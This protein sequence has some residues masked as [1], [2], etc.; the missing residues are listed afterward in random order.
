MTQTFNDALRLMT[1]RTRSGQSIIIIAIGFIVLIAF[2]GIA[3]DAALLFVRYST[4]RRAIDAAAVAA[5]GQIREN[6]S[7]AQMAAAAQQYIQVHGLEASSVIVD[8]CETEINN[9]RNDITKNI[10]GIYNGVGAAQAWLADIDPS[11]KVPR[12]DLCRKDPAKLVRVSAQIDS[13]TTFLSVLGYKTIR[14]TASAI[15]QTAVMD[16]VL[17][18]DGS[19][20]MAADTYALQTATRSNNSLAEYAAREDELDK[21]PGFYRGNPDPKL[22]FDLGLGKYNSANDANVYDGYGRLVRTRPSDG[23]ITTDAP[24]VGSIR[25]ECRVGDPGEASRENVNL[26]RGQLGQFLTLGNY[27]W[28]GCCNDPTTQIDASDPTYGNPNR[29][30]DYNWFIDARTGV[31]QTVAG[32]NDPNGKPSTSRVKDGK[33]DGNF[34]DLVCR[35]FKDV[36]DATRRFL[37]K[38]DFT[39]GD[40]AIMIQFDATAH[41]I[42]P[43]GG[44]SP[45]FIDRGS[46]INALNKKVGIEENPNGFAFSCATHFN[47]AR[48]WGRKLTTADPSGAGT[49]DTA[50]GHPLGN[51]YEFYNTP[52]NNSEFFYETIAPCPDTNTGAAIQAGTALLADPTWIRRDAVWIAV[53]LSDGYP[54]RTPGLGV[55]D[56]DGTLGAAT[57]GLPGVSFADLPSAGLTWNPN[58]HQVPAKGNFTLPDAFGVQVAY[59][60]ATNKS[61]GSFFDKPRPFSS[62]INDPGFCPWS[63]FC[64]PIAGGG[65]ANDYGGSYSE[66]GGPYGSYVNRPANGTN[67]FPDAT[68]Q[69]YNSKEWWTQYCRDVVK[70]AEPM[71]WSFVQNSGAVNPTDTTWHEGGQSLGARKPICSSSNP[72]ARHFCVETSSG[73]ISPGSGVC[74]T[75]YDAVDFA[76]DRVDFAAL[77][78]YTPKF[79]GNFIAMFSIFFPHITTD[80]ARPYN[81]YLRDNI[82][83]VKFMRYV[84]DAG[85]NGVIDNPLQRWYRDQAYVGTYQKDP[86][87]GG[88]SLFD[89]KIGFNSASIPPSYSANPDPCFQYDFREDA[90]GVFPDYSIANGNNPANNRFEDLARTTCGN[91]YYAGDRTAVDRAFTDIATRLFT[92][93][94]R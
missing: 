8:T 89:D 30:T 56:N 7:Y 5:A 62:T 55:T 4:L 46:A 86:M 45:V 77:I 90:G 35:P 94:A 59:G 75:Y 22:G 88:S 72:D 31:I 53:L 71:W 65:S 44:G 13:P 24:G 27:A 82:L 83:G 9:L 14:L 58:F 12:S 36:R 49:I 21:F 76:R 3:T 17:M 43:S 51:S 15:S 20:S 37:L 39:R 10:G 19:L 64:D 41:P 81:N 54:N 25:G 6:S 67:G 32:A 78:D 80:A 92:R 93:L 11:T 38:V 28:G 2:V 1:R 42:T 85:D 66:V 34:A 16:V 50:A 26:P 48:D 47:Y 29:L 79:K 87:P 68:T 23:T 60:G 57:Y 40:R 33:R 84:A 69:Y 61:T 70:N 18:I 91:Y 63:T 52:Y 74:S 73:R